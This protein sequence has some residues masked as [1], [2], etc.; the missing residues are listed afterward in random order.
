MSNTTFILV[1]LYLHKY[2]E[3]GVPRQRM[4]VFCTAYIIKMG[5][6]AAMCIFFIFL[7]LS[8]VYLG[9]HSYNQVVFGGTL[10]IVLAAVGHYSI[11]PH[12]L[13]MQ[14]KMVK[15]DF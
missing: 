13:G 1:S 9:A 14:D 10:G 8:R 11:K 5:V 6:T 3:V 2:Y 15:V 4:S 12:F 7:G